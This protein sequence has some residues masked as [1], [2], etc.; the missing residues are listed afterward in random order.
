MNWQKE[1]LTRDI[2]ELELRELSITQN[3]V[4]ERINELTAELDFLYDQNRE[5]NK[6]INELTRKGA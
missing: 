5:I 3:Q 6:K 4:E 1:D 2:K